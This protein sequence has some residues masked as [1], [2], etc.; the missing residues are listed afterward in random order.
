MHGQNVTVLGAGVSGLTTAL[1]LAE[2]GFRVQIMTS[3]LPRDTTSCVAAA[4]WYPYLVEP[5]D[6]A[7]VWGCESYH[8][9]FALA[10]ESEAG[11]L[12]RPL[13][14]LFQKQVTQPAWV[15]YVRGF[16][17]LA[18]DQLLPGFHYGFRLETAVV[19][20]PCYLPYLQHKLAQNGVSISIQ[21][22][23]SLGDA[24]SKDSIVVNCTGLGAQSFAT[25][26][27][28]MRYAG[29]SSVEKA[30]RPHSSPSVPRPRLGPSILCREVTTAS[31]VEL[32][33]FRNLLCLTWQPQT[34]SCSELNL[35]CQGWRNCATDIHSSA[36]ALV[37]Q[38]FG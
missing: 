26:P 35:Q 15:S 7:A 11:I 13:R 2:A 14:V 3:Q 9:F 8:R 5:V 1:A 29:K 30:S 38:R 18:A 21:A 19:E 27:P 17:W 36:C 20:M 16:E 32:A 22:Q 31:L 10:N 25:I 37:V 24:A 4:F 12:L 28:C 6:K 23:L 34:A 33:N